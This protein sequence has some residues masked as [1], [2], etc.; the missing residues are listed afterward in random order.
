MY[1]PYTLETIALIA[2]FL[3][4]SVYKIKD[5]SKYALNYAIVKPHA[6]L[7]SFLDYRDIGDGETGAMPYSVQDYEELDIEDI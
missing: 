3:G 1:T 6:S 7:E 2:S 4:Y 5:T